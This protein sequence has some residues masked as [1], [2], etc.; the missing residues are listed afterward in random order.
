MDEETFYTITD[1]RF[2]IGTV[3]MVNSLRLMG[4]ESDDQRRRGLGGSHIPGGPGRA[5]RPPDER[6]AGGVPLRI[7]TGDST[8]HGAATL[9]RRACRRRP[10]LLFVARK[11]CDARTPQRQNKVVGGRGWNWQGR[12]PYPTLLRRLV[13]G[14][15]VRIR[16]SRN[17]IPVLWLR[18][19]QLGAVGMRSLS[20]ANSVTRIR[21]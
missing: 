1:E 18:P 6:S 5:E 19:G 8:G 14:R 13:V 2:F 10:A 15:D 3:A 4:H 12:H 17:D 16:V 9:S 20:L 7:V 11:A 21:K